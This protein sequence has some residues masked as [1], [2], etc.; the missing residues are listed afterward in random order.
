MADD[1]D[2]TLK[3][4]DETLEE[5]TLPRAAPTQLTIDNLSLMLEGDDLYSSE[6]PPR[7]ELP[8]NSLVAMG[9]EPAASLVHRLPPSFF[10]SVEIKCL[11]CDFSVAPT[12]IA[13]VGFWGNKPIPALAHSQ[14]HRHGVQWIF[15][16]DDCQM[17]VSHTAIPNNRRAPNRFWKKL[18]SIFKG[19]IS[20]MVVGVVLGLSVVMAIRHFWG[21]E[22][23]YLNWSC[24]CVGYWF[25][26]V[27]RSLWRKQKERLKDWA[28]CIGTPVAFW[29]SIAA[30]LGKSSWRGLL[31]AFL[32][33]VLGYNL[34]RLWKRRRTKNEVSDG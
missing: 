11:D 5:N 31:F 24:G 32:G 33:S 22:A 27:C 26:S 16:D 3:E 14:T 15:Y 21:F 8:T 10:S 12:P 28:F 19:E 13:E 30:L 18:L 34:Y 29:A 25:A 1:I 23:W 9:S 4:I 2:K 17:G 6:P 20:A 7:H